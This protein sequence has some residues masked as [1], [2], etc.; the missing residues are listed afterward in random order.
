MTL[1]DFASY[2]VGYLLV[3]EPTT[4][5]DIRIALPTGDFLFEVL[6]TGGEMEKSWLVGFPLA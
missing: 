3:S 1:G 5:T 2:G 6:S 4:P